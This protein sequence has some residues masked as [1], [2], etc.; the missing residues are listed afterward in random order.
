MKTPLEMALQ[1]L[2]PELFDKPMG[3]PLSPREAMWVWARLFAGTFFGIFFCAAVSIV[4]ALLMLVPLL[5]VEARPPGQFLGLILGTAIYCL[6]NILLIQG[7]PG[8]RLVHGALFGLLLPCALLGL[9]H[10]ATTMLLLSCALASVGGLLLSLSRRYRAMH[11]VHVQIRRLR[12]R[13]GRLG[14]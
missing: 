6:G 10:G 3:L 1:D 14:R 5:P 13:H 4:S 11:A 9:L 12:R 2:L 7:F 8:A